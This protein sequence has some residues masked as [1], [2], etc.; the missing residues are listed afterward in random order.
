MSL[1][2]NTKLCDAKQSQLLIIDIQKRLASAMPSDVI[3]RVIANNNILLKAANELNIPVVYSEQYP[4][5]LGNTLPVISKH[6]NNESNS[7]IKTS[8]SC[9]GAEGFN[10]II[11]KQK[12]QQIII[13]G[14]ESHVCVLQSAIQLHRSGYSI[15]VVEDAICS[16]KKL[17]HKNAVERL[18]Q[19]GI[20]VSNVE[21]VLFEW[22]QNA[23]HPKF[24]NISQLIK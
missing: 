23:E 24:K 22:L 17:N 4:T 7:I 19:D 9:S 2:I 10:E 5:G 1:S 12:R 18:R 16:R 3:E 15:Y 13:S 8:F 20:I 6:F 11:A 14:I 21:S